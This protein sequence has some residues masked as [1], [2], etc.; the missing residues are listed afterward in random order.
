MWGDVRRR[1]RAGGA[2]VAGLA[3]VIAARSRAADPLGPQAPPRAGLAAKPGPPAV[4][5]IPPPAMPPAGTGA[6]K[7]ITVRGD[8]LT[9]RVSDVP[10]DEVLQRIAEPS[11]AEIR[12]AVASPRNVTADFA[13]VPLQD[14]I[15]RLLGQ[16]NFLLTYRV[17]GRLRRLTLLGGPV[18]ASGATRVVKTIPEPPPQAPNPTTELF[19][20]RVPVGGRLKGFLGQDNATLQ[21]LMDIA[22]RQDD[23]ALRY[24]AV[25][26]GL[27]AIDAQPDLQAAVVKSLEGTDTQVIE[28][29]LRA[30]APDRATEI[31]THMMGSRVPE[32]RVRGMD[33]TRRMRTPAAQAAV[34]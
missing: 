16:Q 24:E 17:D 2:F 15:T 19:Q 8:L 12:G 22:L 7:T 28:N 34:P 29:L 26:S 25:T 33:I 32:L 6:T 10:L 30:M 4:P 23:A 9:V 21:Q 27:T 18:E 20:R 14:G 5:S 13:D 11:T 31:L 3:L 1:A